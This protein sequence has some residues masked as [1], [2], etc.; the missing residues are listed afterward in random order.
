MSF[1]SKL[2]GTETRRPAADEIEVIR[3]EEQLNIGSETVPAGTVR[4]HKRWKR[5]VVDATT[6]RFVQFYDGVEHQPAAEQDSGE[7]E[8]L[9]DGSVSIPILE[10]RL[11]VSRETFVRERII[12]RRRQEDREVTIRARLRHEQVEVDADEDAEVYDDVDAGGE[13]RNGAVPPESGST[14]AGARRSPR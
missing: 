11:I 4:A 1:F 3:H 14:R 12:L 7:I 5:Q 8:T 13:P 6:P 10:E 9:P 2:F